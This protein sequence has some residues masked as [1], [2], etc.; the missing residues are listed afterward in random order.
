MQALLYT[1][2]FLGREVKEARVARVAGP[3]GKARAPRIRP[4]GQSKSKIYDMKTRIAVSA[5]LALVGA[6]SACSSDSDCSL[7]GVCNGATGVC[8]CDKPWT[9]SL[10]ENLQFKPVSFPQGYGM[11]PNVTTW[12]GGVI[13][14]KD[15]K[16][17]LFVSRMTNDCPL[18]T[19]TVNS[20]IDHAVADR[21]VGP[22]TF[23]DVA[24]NTWAHNA[25]P[26]TLADGTYALYHI[27]KGTGGPDSGKN[28][29]SA[30]SI[31]RRV[32][33]SE[34][35][36]SSSSRSSSRR[37]TGSTIHVSKSLDGPWVPLE[38]T[39]GGCNNPAPWVHPNGTIYVGCGTSLKR[40]T[41]PQGP[42]VDVSVSS[43]AGKDERM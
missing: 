18:S 8:T 38:N 35:G 2:G 6:A 41:E 17:H 13:Q 23:R 19:W 28:C 5:L 36:S 32:S 43:E 21:V 40:A 14:G 31:T 10:C 15:G 25:A 9:G 34:S 33:F 11:L 1:F 29:S 42:Y 27:G 20:R 30:G 22:Y 24:V 12:G 7:N 39:L 26:V 16:F 4:R 3:R 37:S